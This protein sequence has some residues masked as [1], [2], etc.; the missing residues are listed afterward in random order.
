MHQRCLYV[1]YGD[2]RNMHAIIF[3]QLCK[4]LHTEQRSMV[5]SSPNISSI[6][7]S[8]TRL[9][10]L[11]WHQHQTS[12]SGKLQHICEFRCILLLIMISCF[13]II[14]H[15]P[16]CCIQEPM[17]TYKKKVYRNFEPLTGVF[18]KLKITCNIHYRS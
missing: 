4:I 9:S 1:V 10:L 12:G 6:I 8:R 13:P 11:H 15:Q 7:I 5:S 3:C 17:C 2:M 18:F 16:P 14:N